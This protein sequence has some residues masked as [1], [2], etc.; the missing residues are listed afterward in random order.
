MKAEWVHEKARFFSKTKRNDKCKNLILSKHALPFIHKV[1]YMASFF[2]FF[3][4]QGPSLEIIQH[5]LWL[6]HIIKD[7]WENKQTN[8]KTAG[9]H[10]LPH[11]RTFLLLKC[12]LDL[13]VWLLGD[14]VKAWKQQSSCWC[15]ANKAQHQSLGSHSF[16]CFFCCIV[17]CC[18]VSLYFFWN[19]RLLLLKWID[20]PCSTHSPSSSGFTV[21]ARWALRL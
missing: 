16:F 11:V 6:W 17:N 1:Q 13:R 7:W 2:F 15:C 5:Q 10:T 18:T 9:R 12:Y 14:G 8:T 21:V 4:F 19:P 3:F 20:R